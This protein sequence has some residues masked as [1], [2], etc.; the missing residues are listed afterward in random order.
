MYVCVVDGDEMNIYTL[1]DYMALAEAREI[2]AVPKNMFK[3]GAL[4][5]SFV[6][7]ACVAVYCLT[8]QEAMFPLHSVMQWLCQGNNDRYVE[9]ALQ[10]FG[11]CTQVSSRRL[12]QGLLPNYDGQSVMTKKSMNRYAGRL[13]ELDWKDDACARMG[14]IVRVLHNYLLAKGASM[15]MDDVEVPEISV[16]SQ[17]L[18]DRMELHLE[19]LLELKDSTTDLQV[20][21][22]LEEAIGEDTDQLRDIA[23]DHVIACLNKQQSW[24]STI[25]HSGAKGN[26][27]H[28][29]QNVG[30]VGQQVDRNSVRAQRLHSHTGK[31]MD[32]EGFVQNSFVDGLTAIEFFHHLSVS[33]LGF[34]ATAVVTSESGYL[35]RCLSKCCEDLR[36]IYNTSVVDGKGT[37]TFW[38]FGFDSDH[39]K[40]QRLRLI[41]MSATEIATKYLSHTSFASDEVKRLLRLRSELLDAKY[42]HRSVYSPLDFEDL[43]VQIDRAASVP[44][45]ADD[46]IISTV[47]D[48]WKRLVCEFYVPE[49]LVF[50]AL[51]FDELSAFRL[52]ARGLVSVPQLHCVVRFVFIVL[53]KNVVTTDTA[54]GAISSQ[55]IAAPITQLNLNSFHIAG[56]SST[57]NTGVQRIKEIL[58][59]TKKIAAPSMKVFVKDGHVLEGLSLV[60]FT[61]QDA[62]RGW[63]TERTG[64][65]LEEG[66][67]GEKKEEGEKVE[68]EEEGKVFLCL[69]LDKKKMQKREMAPRQIA[70]HVASLPT[71]SAMPQEDVVYTKDLEDETWRVVLRLPAASTNLLHW[72]HLIIHDRR[73]L[74]GIR[75]IDNFYTAVQKV[76]MVENDMLMK[77]NRQ[78]IITSGSNLTDICKHPRCGHSPHHHQRHS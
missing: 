47:T 56:Q 57:V 63:T 44:V 9:E 52:R 15:G 60:S 22:E 48:L 12:V 23:G 19:H 36:T 24:L 4:I 78:V 33:R 26:S 66:G 45:V 6:Q 18:R 25:V 49:S 64:L 72:A 3:E 29:V 41:E 76:N 71:V 77:K 59:L 68:G 53:S 16:P 35:S 62:V 7:H 39:L 38:H 37:I 75:G 69:C 61:M 2:M 73:L 13:I 21:K 8:S 5:V 51:F 54:I 58:H 17:Q 65:F 74:C 32:L 40:L 20:R 50:E 70:E 10:S 43:T 34:V 55:N 1:F 46:L 28:L 14:F 31:L 27:T 67:D 30:C 11:A 42:V